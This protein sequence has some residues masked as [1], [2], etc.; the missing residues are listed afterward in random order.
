MKLVRF[1]M[2]LNNETVTIELK[3]G[4][5]VHGTITGVDMSMNTHLKTV[6]MTVKN[7]DPVNLDSLSIR[8]NNVRYYI[9]PDSLPL[10]TLLVDDTPKAKA[11]KKEAVGVGRGRGRGRGRGTRGRGRGR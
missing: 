11:K 8:G 10:D 1:L 6:K 3:N 7:K 2:K 9:L 5:I 4:T